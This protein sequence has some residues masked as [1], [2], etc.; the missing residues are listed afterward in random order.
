MWGSL[1]WAVATF[2][3]GLL[4]NI[5]PAAKLPQAS[6]AVPGWCSLSCWRGCGSPRRRMRCR[7]SG[8]RR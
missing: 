6:P 8:I 5:N 1:G 7:E 3:A 2:F 4:F